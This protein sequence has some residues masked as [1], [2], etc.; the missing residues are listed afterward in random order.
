[1]KKSRDSVR[2]KI[3]FLLFFPFHVSHCLPPKMDHYK[4]D[5]LNSEICKYVKWVFSLLAPISRDELWYSA[6][7]R[8]LYLKA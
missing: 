6:P 3:V 5:F 2:L 8:N 4:W 7:K 1:M